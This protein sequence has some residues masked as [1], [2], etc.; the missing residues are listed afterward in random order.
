[1]T[2]CYNE[3]QGEWP[4]P[5]VMFSRAHC[6]KTFGNLCCYWK[7][8]DIAPL[9]HSV[10]N[11]FINTDP[12]KSPLGMSAGSL[13]CFVIVFT[14]QAPLQPCSLFQMPSIPFA[15]A[16]HTI[17]IVWCVN[18]RAKPLFGLISWNSSHLPLHFSSQCHFLFICRDFLCSMLMHLSHRT[19]T[20]LCPK[21]HPIPCSSALCRR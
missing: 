8:S 15:V 2:G 1:M 14:I 19:L 13:M 16:V 17:P 7:S 4:P 18:E 6:N 20:S 21:W 5:W 9:F 11:P 3:L 12:G 10:S